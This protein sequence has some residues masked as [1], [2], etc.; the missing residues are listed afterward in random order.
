MLILRRKAGQSLLIGDGIKVMVLE[1]GDGAVRLAIDAPKEIPILRSE[2]LR[3]MDVNRDA[4]NEES[5][6]QELLALL[7]ELRESGK[8]PKGV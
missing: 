3:A 2:L 7:G 6:P 5:G 4:A 8:P 1:T